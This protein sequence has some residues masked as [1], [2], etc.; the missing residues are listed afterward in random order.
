MGAWVHQGT[1]WNDGQGTCNSGVI[2]GKD[3]LTECITDVLEVGVGVEVG[4]VIERTLIS[5][6][7]CDGAAGW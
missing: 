5:A 6:L 2:D 3:V 1:A 7:L 4:G